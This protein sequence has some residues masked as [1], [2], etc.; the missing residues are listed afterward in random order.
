MPRAAAAYLERALRGARAGRR[1][2]DDARPARHGGVRRRPAGLAAAPARGAARGARP[3]RPDRRAHAP[4]LVEPGATPA[5]ASWCGLFDAELAGETDPDVRLAIEA[6]RLDALLTVPE[7]H[8]ERARRVA[9]I[10]LSRTADPLLAAR[11]AR[12]P[13]VGR[14]RARHGRRRDRRDAGAA[15]RSRAACCWRRRTGARAYAICARVLDGGRPSRGGRRDPGPARRGGAARVAAAARRGRVVRGRARAADRPRGRRREPARLALELVDEGLNTFTGGA[16]RGAGL[17]ARR[18]RRVRRGARAAARATGSTARWA[19]CRGRSACATPARGWRWP[20]ATTSARTPRR[21]RPARCAPPRAARTRRWRR[22][23]RPRR[24]ALAHLGRRDEAA[25]LADAELALAER[26]GAPLPI[27]GALARPRR[28]RA[29]PRRARRALRA[30]AGGR[31]R[32][33]ASSR[34]GCGSSSAARW[35][36][37]A[38]ASRRATRCV[39]RWPTPTRRARCC[40]SERARREL[41]ATGLRPRQAALEGTAALT[42]RQRQ[43]CE[44]AAVGKGNRAIAQELFLSVKTVETH[45]AAGYRKLGVN[46]RAELAAE[47]AAA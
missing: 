41:V 10:D 39:R 11:R 32:A 3:R 47:L 30:R 15:R 22:G 5:T 17:R 6:A 14:H 19:C 37:W 45:L 1:P 40:S 35:P 27:A 18:A 31:R 33:G 7:R 21:W 46:T 2:R 28:R 38:G 44:L 20:R 13:R 16:R 36:T 29:R 26:F 23:A 8:A 24:C 4:R 9:A 42:P 12:A 25:A 34:C 43:I